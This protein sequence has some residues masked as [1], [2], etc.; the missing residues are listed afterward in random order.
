M[1]SSL[2][3]PGLVLVVTHSLDRLCHLLGK[4]RYPLPMAGAKQFWGQ[5]SHGGKLI[6][7]QSEAATA[8]LLQGLERN[9]SEC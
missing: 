6:L 3:T 4:L 2:L 9:L 1:S 8:F 5:V 7:C